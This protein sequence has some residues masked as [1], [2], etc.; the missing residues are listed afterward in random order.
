MD[1]STIASLVTAV[2]VSLAG[3]WKAVSALIQYFKK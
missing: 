1:I 3:V 2:V